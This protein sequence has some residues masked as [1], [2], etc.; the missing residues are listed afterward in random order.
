M[1]E[2]LVA[3]NVEEEITK[4][5][6]YTDKVYTS[7]VCTAFNQAVYI[8]DAI[9]SFLAQVTEY[10]FE[11]IIHDDASTDTTSDILKVY[12]QKYPSIIKLILQNRNQYS[13]N[14]HM[15][16]SHSLEIAEGEYIAICEGDDFWVLSDKLQQ[17]IVALQ[18]SSKKLTFH[19]GYIL[20]QSFTKCKI[21]A[22]SNEKVMYSAE[23]IIQL[24]SGLMQT[25]SMMFCKKAVYPF[26]NW[27]YYAPVGDLY[28]QIL[29]SVP[30]G[31]IYL[32]LKGSVYRSL[33][34]GSWSE[35]NTKINGKNLLERVRL[36]S[37]SLDSTLETIGIKYQKDINKQKSIKYYENALLALSNLNYS[38]FISLIEISYRL[39][40]SV[41]FKV[42]FF[43]VIRFLPGFF[44]YPMK[45]LKWLYYMTK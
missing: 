24:N 18:S 11:I 21:Q 7:V 17:Q 1:F 14:C 15:P 37:D 9:D 13:I 26:P 29:A 8:R 36:L 34:Q 32:P 38:A 39:E 41:S 31:A 2:K 25:A 22:L 45:I 20:R 4:H 3:P 19:A 43:Y 35:N 27:F 12:Q 10:K 42:K 40:C 44:K 33:T 6:K 16:L 5:W 30:D 28:I 23:D